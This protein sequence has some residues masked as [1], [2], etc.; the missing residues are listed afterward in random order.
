MDEARDVMRVKVWTSKPE[1][2]QK[3]MKIKQKKNKTEGGQ[4]LC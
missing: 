1:A 2:M 4:P 3:I